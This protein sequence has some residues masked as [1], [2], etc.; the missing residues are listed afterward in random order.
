ML[1]YWFVNR[2]MKKRDYNICYFHLNDLINQK[3]KLKS[4]A[5]YEEYFKEPGTLKNRVM[6]YVK[7]NIGTGDAYGKM[8]RLLTEHLFVSVKEADKMIDWDKID[9]IRL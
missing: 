8:E 6:R 9:V 3:F 4:R 7:S 5:E 1:P 2:T